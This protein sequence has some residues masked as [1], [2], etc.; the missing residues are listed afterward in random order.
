MKKL[1]PFSIPRKLHF[2]HF[3]DL[4]SEE[5]RSADNVPYF[6]QAIPTLVTKEDNDTVCKEISEEETINAICTLEPDKTPRRG[7]IIHFFELVGIL[8]SMTL[9]T[10]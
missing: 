1:T 3:N 7:F 6:L 10:C 8:S 5:P 4:Y 9:F 2:D